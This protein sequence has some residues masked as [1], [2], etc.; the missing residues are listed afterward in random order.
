MSKGFI[1][2]ILYVVSVILLLIGVGCAC[3]IKASNQR[4]GGILL[5]LFTL[6]ML[7]AP[8]IVKLGE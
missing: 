1:Y 2:A 8:E 3:D 5:G 7:L 6:I 4:I